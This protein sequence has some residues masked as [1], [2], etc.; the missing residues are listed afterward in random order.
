MLLRRITVH[1]FD[2]RPAGAGGT[3]VP[4]LRP[5][6]DRLGA[7]DAAAVGPLCLD[8]HPRRPAGGGRE[9][10]FGAVRGNLIAC[11]PEHACTRKI[12]AGWRVQAH[13]DALACFSVCREA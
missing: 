12:E 4:T 3:P 7:E 1:V 10:E 9:A 11:F 2:V 6:G 8:L 5:D 13:G